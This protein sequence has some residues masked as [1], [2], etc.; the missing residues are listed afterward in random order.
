MQKL[1]RVAVQQIRVG[2]LCRLHIMSLVI[3]FGRRRHFKDLIRNIGPVA[4]FFAFGGSGLPRR[5]REL[6]R[7]AVVRTKQDFGCR[8]P[9]LK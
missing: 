3:L 2:F 1:R 9:P 5:S 6:F 4:A 7:G 8:Q